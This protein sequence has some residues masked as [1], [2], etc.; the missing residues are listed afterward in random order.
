MKACAGSEVGSGIMVATQLSTNTLR[1]GCMCWMTDA[2][3]L[4]MSLRV[5]LLEVLSDFQS[6]KKQNNSVDVLIE[7]KQKKL[8]TISSHYLWCVAVAHHS[9]AAEKTAAAS[10]PLQCLCG[11]SMQDT[12]G[13]SAHCASWKWIELVHQHLY[14]QSELHTITLLHIAKTEQLFG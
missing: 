13:C 3:M 12:A 11:P 5:N 2:C 14:R 4:T 6:S 1:G 10:Q 8:K 9:W 7:K